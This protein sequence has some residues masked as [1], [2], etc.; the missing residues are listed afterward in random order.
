MTFHI[1]PTFEEEARRP[2]PEPI[3]PLVEP[4]PQITRPIAAPPPAVEEAEF[5]EKTQIGA[6]APIPGE[7]RERF[8]PAAEEAI[9]PAVPVPIGLAEDVTQVTAEIAPTAAPVPVPTGLE[10]PAVT[11]EAGFIGV[12]KKGEQ[13]LFDTSAEADKSKADVAAKEAADKE[14][15]KIELKQTG[16]LE[17]A[18]ELVNT[19]LEFFSNPTEAVGALYDAQVNQFMD[20]I[21]PQNL[22]LLN[23]LTFK[24]KQQGFEGQPVGT[25]MI[26]TMARLQGKQVSEVI[27]GFNTEA[28]EKIIAM[29]KYAGKFGLQVIQQINTERQ[30]EFTNNRLLIT[31]A[32]LAGDF[33]VVE[34]LWSRMS[35]GLPLDTTALE[36]GFDRDEIEAEATLANKLG[37]HEPF[38]QLAESAF[39]QID[40]DKGT[41]LLNDPA[42][43]FAFSARMEL[44][45]QA[46]TPEDRLAQ[47]QAIARDFPEQFGFP[48]DPDAAVRAVSQIDFTDSSAQLDKRE[49]IN[50][51]L[52]TEATKDEV[53]IDWDG[54]LLNAKQLFE[55]DNPE[56]LNNKFENTL[57][58]LDEA[59][60]QDVFDNLA[61]TGS[62]LTSLADIETV[63]DKIE[64]LAMERFTEIRNS[65]IGVLTKEIFEQFQKESAESPELSEWFTDPLLSEIAKDYFAQVILGNLYTI[66]EDDNFIVDSSKILPPWS[67]GSRSQNRYLTWPIM[68]DPDGNFLPEGYAGDEPWSDIN[69]D[70]VINSLDATP[71]Q[72][73]LSESW[74]KFKTNNPSVTWLEWYHGTKGNTGKFS[75]ANVDAAIA[76]G[77]LSEAEI[78]E[79]EP[80][81]ELETAEE[82]QQNAVTEFN[83]SIETG[84]FSALNDEEWFFLLKGKPENITKLSDSEKVQ[85]F[86]EADLFGDDIIRKSDFLALGLRADVEIDNDITIEGPEP[87]TGVGDGNGSIILVN[88]RPARIVSW[89]SDSEGSAL[90][91]VTGRRG[92]IMVVFLDE[93]PTT[94]EPVKVGGSSDFVGV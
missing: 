19:T 88:G 22:Q 16:Q 39:P 89:V 74:D 13:K 45:K 78:G 53:A 71:M 92:N 32:A 38:R 35:G 31:D 6:P 91:G 20:T 51:D 7:L 28:V 90:A 43:Q 70:G 47:M 52:Q 57:K 55:N 49:G 4:A 81:T 64:F 34:E 82:F 12:D 1:T 79:R 76:A 83:T 14:R 25:A 85:S 3:Q 50:I 77:V 27:A 58:L 86:T 23:A 80:P 54:A 94:R 5:I 9:T 15:K 44:A 59:G 21:N 73:S 66:D 42:R 84:D 41:F 29:N 33:D 93:D 75:D 61:K 63:E 48:G 10:A 46:A 72:T 17:E 26:F 36:R 62:I 8:M 56:L 60:I 18:N 65:D 40:F 87:D 67:D 24:I 30:L 68:Y 37:V 69:K 11:E 2:L